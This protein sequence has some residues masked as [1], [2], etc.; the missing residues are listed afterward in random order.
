MLFAFS[1]VLSFSFALSI[2]ANPTAYSDDVIDAENIEPVEYQDSFMI[3]QNTDQADHSAAKC[4]SMYRYR[5]TCGGPW[6]LD[7]QST[8]LNCVPS[9]FYKP[10]HH[11]ENIYH[12][13]D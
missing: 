6:I 9:M 4:D 2:F 10:L 12:H 11:T 8:I 5:V 7:E 1:I 3:S 13:N